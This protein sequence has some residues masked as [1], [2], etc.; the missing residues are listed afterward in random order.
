MSGSAQEPEPGA[1][2]PLVEEVSPDIYAYIQPDGSWFLNNMA[3]LVG[4]E[5][6][7]LIDTTSTESRTRA[8]LA[9][10]ASVTDL[11]VRTLVNTHSHGD[12]THGNY[13]LPAATIVA[14]HGCRD[15]VIEGGTMSTAMFPEVDWGDLR[16]A[17]PFVTFERDL[18]VFVDDL[19]VELHHTGPAHTTNDV[20]AWVPERR[21][22]IAGDLVFNGGCPFVMMGSVAGSIDAVAELQALGAERIIPGHGPVCGPAAL[23]GVEAYLRFVQSVAVDGV[24]A[25]WTPLEAAQRADLG[26][27]A[28]WGETERLA[29]NL[30]RAYSELRGEPRGTPLPLGALLADMVAF[31][32]GRL[33]HCLA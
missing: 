1:P 9:A 18:T 22:L 27:F 29:P 21:L 16:V 14:Q 19:R 13:L 7:V 6:V 11:P 26:P 15:A 31:N 32:G 2:P 3:F 30:H 5:G 12:H 33:P 28:L 20:Y 25:G 10:I 24:A 4:S 23:D 8:L 17:P